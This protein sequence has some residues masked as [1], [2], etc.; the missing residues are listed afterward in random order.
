MAPITHADALGYHEVVAKFIAVNGTFPKELN[1][2]Q[3]LLAG[4]GEV[5]MSLSFLFNSEQLGNLI[6]YSGLLSIVGVIRKNS[7]NNIK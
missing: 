2:F 6:Q 4:S 7:N 1:N 3:N 5:M